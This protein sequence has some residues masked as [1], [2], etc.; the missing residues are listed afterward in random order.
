MKISCDIWSFWDRGMFWADG[1]F[2][3]IR[4]VGKLEQC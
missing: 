2:R 1:E 4:V 3:V